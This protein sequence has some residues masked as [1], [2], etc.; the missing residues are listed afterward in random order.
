LFSPS[1]QV[2]H[3]LAIERPESNLNSIIITHI[4]A[5]S[6]LAKA[7]LFNVYFYSVFTESSNHP[8]PPDVIDHPSMM[9]SE[10]NI[11]DD[12]VLNVLLPPKPWDL[13]E[14]HP[15]SYKHVL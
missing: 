9:I 8:L 1:T 12:E 11:S 15:L 3:Q 13:M 4:S 7:S 10:L 2:T 5:D 6:D 14:Y